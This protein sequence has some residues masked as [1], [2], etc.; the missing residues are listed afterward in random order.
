[1]KLCTAGGRGGKRYR[2]A[3]RLAGEGTFD[4]WYREVKREP[5]VE[6]PR[7]GLF[8]PAQDFQSTACQRTQAKGPLG[9]LAAPTEQLFKKGNAQRE[10]RQK[11]VL[12]QVRSLL[13]AI[14]SEIRFALF[15][16]DHR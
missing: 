8:P 6:F 5:G 13:Q 14:V 11:N 4:D 10:G 3:I 2:T 9:I 16:C 7:T 15:D 1:M 12:H